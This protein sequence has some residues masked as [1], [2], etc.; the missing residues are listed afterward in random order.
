MYAR[1]NKVKEKLAT[2]EL[3]VGMEHWIRD[4]RLIELMGYAG[5]DFVDIENEHIARDWVA[6][7]ND[8]RAAELAGLTPMYRT[9]QCVDNQPPSN[10]IIKAMKLG[11]QILKIPHVNTAECARKVVEAAKY[12][13]LGKRGIATCDRGMQDIYP[14]PDVPLDIAR[15]T[16]EA[17]DEIMIW[18]IIETPEAVEN[19]DAIL[20]VEGID[21][22]GF[23]HQDYTLASGN[24]ADSGAHIEEA[25]EKVFE[26]VK[27]KGK[28]M[29]WN[30]SSTKEVMEQYNRGIQISLMGCD[31]IHINNM[32]RQFMK[33]MKG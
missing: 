3:I 17:N 25:R 30:A 19:I 33:E 15:Y 24:S 4:P 18:A 2:G 27:R 6:I 16:Q 21:C 14:T 23:G 10:E 11:I 8:V 1:K 9:G 13:P 29:W 28:L 20:D 31:I 32:Y 22:V 26:A 5:F 7:E 12:P